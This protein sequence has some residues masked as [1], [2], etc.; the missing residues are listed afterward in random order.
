[1]LGG[2]HRI[3]PL[4][5]LVP[6]RSPI[7]ARETNARRPP[8]GSID[9]G[10]RGRG[11]LSEAKPRKNAWGVST[12]VETAASQPPPP[13]N[14]PQDKMSDPVHGRRKGNI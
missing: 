12:Y 2:H 7:P 3:T 14:Q 6:Y 8:A 4:H 9:Y 5:V 10:V 11:K 1:M 13:P